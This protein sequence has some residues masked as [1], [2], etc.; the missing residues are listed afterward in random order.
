M[1][2][3]IWNASRVMMLSPIA[4]FLAVLFLPVLALN[5][6]IPLFQQCLE[7]IHQNDSL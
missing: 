2:R 6:N 5:E 4:A 1:I 7:F 3:N